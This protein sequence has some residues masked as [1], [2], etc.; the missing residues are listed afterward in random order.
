M[1]EDNTIYVDKTEQ[2]YKLSQKHST[3]TIYPR[4]FG[5]SVFIT[6]I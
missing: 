5:K 4:R 2:I 6:T 3:L 1:L